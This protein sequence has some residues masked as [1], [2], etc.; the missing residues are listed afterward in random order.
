MA[1]LPSDEHSQ[2]FVRLFAQHQREVFKYI[3]TLLPDVSAAQDV[4][5]ETSV[6]LWTKFNEFE[7]GTHFSAW[8][9]RIAYFEVLKHRKSLSRE[10]LL[11]DHDLIE[12]LALDRGE[13]DELLEARRAALDL[14]LDKLSPADRRLVQQCYQ[15]RGGVKQ[16]AEATGR[17]IHTLYKTM[18]RIR[19]R[20]F[21][22]INRNTESPW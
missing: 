3:L 2:A 6:V 18:Q 16:T 20:L 1:S 12:Q 15:E 10:R 7:Q 5:Q 9:C 8:A 22:C 11:F 19:R 13:A 14:C 4:L 21:D 17:S